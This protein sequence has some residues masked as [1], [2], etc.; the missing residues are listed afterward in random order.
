MFKHTVL[1][2]YFY[3]SNYYTHLLPAKCRTD[4]TELG[5]FLFDL[6]LYS[7]LNPLIFHM[8][9]ELQGQF[10]KFKKYVG[11]STN[12]T[13]VRWSND[14][15]MLLSVGGADTALMIW[16]REPP[17]HKETKAV[18]SEESDDDSEEDGGELVAASSSTKYGHTCQMF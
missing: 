8:H 1:H 7:K 6:K 14:D 4:P 13:N 3:Q 15:S 11:H 2:K 9:P 12:V 18:D 10:A 16:S 5:D 17:G